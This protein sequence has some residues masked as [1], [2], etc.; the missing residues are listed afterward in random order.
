MKTDID[1]IKKS[2]KHALDF[3]NRGDL[4]YAESLYETVLEIDPNNPDANHNLGLIF[5]SS[6]E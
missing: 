4:N 1:L 5:V 2:L 3:H 6:H